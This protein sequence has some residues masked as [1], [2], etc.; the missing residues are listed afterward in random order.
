M[1]RHGNAQAGGVA[2]AVKPIPDVAGLV[3]RD[4]AEDVLLVRRGGN[5]RL[6]GGDDGLFL[7][8]LDV[9]RWRGGGSDDGGSHA[10]LD[11]RT[12]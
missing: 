12:K 9:R 3:V 5:V 6:V 10:S 4:A 7:T 11:T 1:D 8:G 2:M